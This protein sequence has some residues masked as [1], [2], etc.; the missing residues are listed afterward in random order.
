V[1]Q[2]RRAINYRKAGVTYLNLM[3]M[4][5]AITAAALVAEKAFCIE[6]T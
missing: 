1:A 3:A 6:K 4:S 5:R 2:S